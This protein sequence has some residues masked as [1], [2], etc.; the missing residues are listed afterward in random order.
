M[1]APASMKKGTAMK[2]KES[3]E[4]N[5]RCTITRSGGICSPKNKPAA[6]AKPRPTPIE[7]PVAR[8]TA[9]DT[10]TIKRTIV[11]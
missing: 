6:E 5:I 10:K 11:S 9:K 1:K 4:V 2:E 8:I 3:T 7:A